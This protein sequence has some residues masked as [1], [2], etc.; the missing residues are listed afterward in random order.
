[1]TSLSVPRV[2]KMTVYVSTRLCDAARSPAEMLTFALPTLMA[3]LLT[4]IMAVALYKGVTKK[5]V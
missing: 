3:L 2:F 5:N 1:M 4:Y